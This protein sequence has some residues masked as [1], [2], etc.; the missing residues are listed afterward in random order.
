LG[1]EAPDFAVGVALVLLSCCCKCG[2]EFLDELYVCLGV[3][4]SHHDPRGIGLSAEAFELISFPRC[5]GA[6]V[7]VCP[8]W[9]VRGSTRR[10]RQ[11]EAPLVLEINLLVPEVLCWDAVAL[12]LWAT[13]KL[14]FAEA[15]TALTG[16]TA[17]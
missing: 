4:R 3:P 8:L 13:R 15:A 11:L 2:L 14:R 6:S 5:E 10:E 9:L 16:P 1:G 12:G 17:E 7:R